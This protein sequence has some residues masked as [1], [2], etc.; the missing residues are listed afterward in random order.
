MRTARAKGIGVQ[1]LIVHHVLR[2]ALMPIIA[3]VSVRFGTLL[4]G[5]ILVEYVFHWPGLSGLLVEAARTRDYP[6]VQGI[7]LMLSLLLI[8]LH[9]VADVVRAALDPRLRMT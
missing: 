2:N 7:V 5:A 6:E 3:V 1:R 4:G 9:L 8:A